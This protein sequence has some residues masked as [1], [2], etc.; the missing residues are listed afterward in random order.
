MNK[1][2]LFF[3]R[4]ASKIIMFQKALQFRSANVL[5]YNKQVTT[6]V[7]SQMPPLLT[8]QNFQTIVDCLSLVVSPFVLN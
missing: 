4:F 1:F 5:Y 2:L 6:R 3:Y 8:W 7:I